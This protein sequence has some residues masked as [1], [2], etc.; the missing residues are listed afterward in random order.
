[1]S[2]S[3][4]ALT[5]LALAV[6]GVAI[7][8]AAIFFRL[9][10]PTDPLLAS[11]MRLAIAGLVLSPFSVRAVQRG[12]LS[13]RALRTAALG[14][15]LY[16]VHFGAWVAS[17]ERTSV[18]AS[19]TIVTATPLLLAVVA[20]ARGR[21]RP[22]R[23][24]TLAT[25][26]AAG[27]AG[28]IGLGDATESGWGALGGDLLALLGALAMA[29]YLLIVRDLGKVPALAFS[30]IA[31]LV[32]AAVLGVAVLVVWPFAAPTPP[33]ADA[34]FFIALAAL[35]PQ[36]IGHGALTWALERATPTEVGLATAIEPVLSTTLAWLVFAERPGSLVVAG[37]LLTLGA[38]V[39]GTT[40]KPG[41]P[42]APG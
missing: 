1:M 21:D 29:V 25:L 8:F 23:R 36:V 35:V 38:V 3:S 10:S 30:G 28:L 42:A 15:V 4:P 26:V 16:A 11:A 24:T 37:A 34:A 33:D 9:A 2:A 5:R 32:G 19:V 14:G 18:A 6:G 17:L 39:A 12:E 31:A 40:G 41:A 22:S 13:A 20:F 7:G 27:G